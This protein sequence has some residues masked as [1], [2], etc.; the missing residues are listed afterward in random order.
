MTVSQQKR[1]LGLI[2]TL[3]LLVVTATPTWAKKKPGGGGGK[4]GG[5]GGGGG[6]AYTVSRLDDAGGAYVAGPSNAANDINESGN[7]V[8]TV[9]DVATGADVPVF[10]EVNG[11]SSEIVA[12]GVNA[13]AN[14]LNN[15]NEIVG[16]GG[17]ALYWP[18]PTAAPI[19]L[20]PLEPGLAAVAR[21]INDDGVICGYA[22]EEV[23][24]ETGDPVGLAFVACVW[25]VTWPAGELL[26]DGPV[27]L[28]TFDDQSQ[29]YA[30]NENDNSGLADVVGSFLTAGWEYTSAVQW[31]VL[32]HADGTISVVSD[33]AALEFGDAAANGVNNLGVS[34]GDAANSARLWSPGNSLTLDSGRRA[35]TVALDV[36]DTGAI[37]GSGGP[38]SLDL[39]ALVW[40][41]ASAA[42]VL[43]A[44]FLPKRRS[45]FVALWN[46]TAINEAGQIAGEGGDG[47]T[48]FAY[49]A[50]PK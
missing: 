48:S 38:H 28:P 40:P 22:L 18:G 7:V 42:P 31:T 26:I 3:S 1:I 49:L 8:G 43:L 45:P 25:R 6:V 39:D 34:C 20:P 11:T 33:P 10:W 13:F 35:Y 15:S 5:K 23:L 50:I 41:D 47:V 36:N 37:V 46:A 16:G 30:L 29:A 19:P 12:I 17:D 4:G 9:L 2:L 14:G 24:D 32:S 27:A 44:K 21:D